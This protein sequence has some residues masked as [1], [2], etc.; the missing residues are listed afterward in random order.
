MSDLTIIYKNKYSINSSLSSSSLSYE[1][2]KQMFLE[3][4]ASLH[5]AALAGSVEILKLLLDHGASANLKDQ[6]GELVYISKKK[7]NENDVVIFR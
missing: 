6:K 4:M 3:K 7:S 1:S 5:Q 2:L